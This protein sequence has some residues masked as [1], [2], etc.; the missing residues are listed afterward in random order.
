MLQ[1]HTLAH[2]RQGRHWGVAPC[3]HLAEYVYKG[4][5]QGECTHVLNAI[6]HGHAAGGW[7]GW[8]AEGQGDRQ[9]CCARA[10]HTRTDAIPTA[11]AER[12]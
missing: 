4:T 3:L 10:E 9:Y 1:I 2:M 11:A 6:Q 12:Q 7:A 8:D 5:V